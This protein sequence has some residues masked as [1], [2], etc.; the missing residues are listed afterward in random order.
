[1][2][3]VAFCTLLAASSVSLSAGDGRAVP[4]SWQAANDASPAARAPVVV[5]VSDGGS[6]DGFKK[7]VA[8]LHEAGISVLAIEPRKLAP[9]DSFGE[10]VTDI[11]AALKW[12][13]ARKDVNVQ[14]VIVAG[15]G[16]GA[17]IALAAAA[18]DVSDVS[19]AGLALLSPG[20]D[21]D[22]LDDVTALGDYGPRPF[23]VLVAKG[24]KKSA[25]SALVLDGNAKGP[26][27][28]HI[29]E[30]SRRGAELLANDAAALA[31]FVEWAKSM[32]TP[33]SSP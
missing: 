16:D 24:D 20:L 9:A 33:S 22:R 29:A 10:G 27:K 32:S 3:G 6:R 4:A 5:L 31:A 25:K 2:F 21:P 12:L 26:K 30:G 11:A 18:S 28:I 8:A 7:T 1:M 13:G 23:F 17:M 19:I 14:R 15:A